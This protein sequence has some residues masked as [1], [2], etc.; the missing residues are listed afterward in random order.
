MSTL[1]TH[2]TTSRD[3]H[4]IG[5]CK[6][7]TTNKAIEVSD[8]S[9]WLIYDYDSSYNPQ[10]NSFAVSYDGTDDYHLVALDG[11][12]TGG[13]LATNDTDVELT[14]SA[15]VKPIATGKT[16]ISWAA[17]STSSAPFVILQHNRLYVDGNFRTLSTSLTQNSWNHVLITRTASS[18]DWNLFLNGNSTAVVTYN[19]SGS[20]D[21]RS[22][23]ETFYVGIGYGGEANCVIDELAFWNSDKSS[24]LTSI[25]GSV[26]PGSGSPT[27]LTSLSPYGWWRMGDGE[28]G[29]ANGGAAGTIT[30]IG[31]TA[32]NLTVGGG[33]PTYTNSV[34]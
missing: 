31:S 4:S 34:V 28:S 1:T 13:V 32:N 10:V 11:T 18:N 29:V 17:T 3:S 19:D 14:I 9:N 21:N 30:N 33:S 20:P 15:W 6:F 16:Y 24:D 2:T 22:A 7:N 12:S 5:L 27:D 26:T 8:G 23:A 25:Y